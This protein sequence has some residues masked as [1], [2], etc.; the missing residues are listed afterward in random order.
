MASVIAA[1]SD[2]PVAVPLIFLAFGVFLVMV[3][4]KAFTD[5]DGELHRVAEKRAR[6]KVVR[7]LGGSGDAAREYAGL[8]KSRWLAPVILVAYFAIVLVA[9]VK[10][11]AG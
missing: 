10:A 11:L 1:S 3:N 6:S 8:R 9:L 4:R 2:I 7:F 5:F